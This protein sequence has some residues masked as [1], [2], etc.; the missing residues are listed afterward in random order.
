MLTD[1]KIALE[2]Y[3]LF[4]P[5]LGQLQTLLSLAL[6]RP[7]SQPSVF[8]TAFVAVTNTIAF[9]DNSQNEVA[10]VLLVG[11]GHV[12]VGEVISGVYTSVISTS[13]SV[14]FSYSNSTFLLALRRATQVAVTSCVNTC[15]LGKPLLDSRSSTTPNAGDITKATVIVENTF[16][17][18][19]VCVPATSKALA[20]NQ[21]LNPTLTLDDSNS[22]TDAGKTSTSEETSDLIPGLRSTTG[23]HAG[24]E[25]WGADLERI[26]LIWN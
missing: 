4:A 21:D 1:E 3:C 19:N 5:L 13:H 2:P 12:F 16:C 20:S 17:S 25:E 24:S 10:I 7:V 23:F 18:Y 15:P 8:T 11:D 6:S 22:N 26:L 14:P 9:A